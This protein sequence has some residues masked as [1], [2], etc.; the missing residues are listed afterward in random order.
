[1]VAAEFAMILPVLI[2]IVLGAVDFGRFAATYIAV[3]NAARAGGQSAMMNNYTASTLSAWQTAITAAARDEITPQV[4][5]TNAANLSVSVTTSTDNGL[6]RAQVVASYPFTTVVNWRW[7]G[8]A[9]PQ[10]VTLQQK[11]EVRLIR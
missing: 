5:A 4:G 3:I 11:V 7:T 2:T 6:K 8:L 9:L 10:S 1:M